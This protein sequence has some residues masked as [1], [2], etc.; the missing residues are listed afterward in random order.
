MEGACLYYLSLALHARGDFDGA[1]RHAL[2]A[3]RVCEHVPPSRAEALAALAHA[4]MAKGEVGQALANAK[5][6]MGILAA[7][8]G[9]DEGEPF[10]RLV[11][12][13]AL[14]ASGALDEA[15]VAIAEARR[16]LEGRAG[17]IV[18]DDARATFVAISENARTLELARLW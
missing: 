1:E 17:K 9:I 4:R 8:G 15:R 12:A 5:E 10:I 7:V 6:A 2:E 18:D 16:H 3:V 13:E 14:H 11:H